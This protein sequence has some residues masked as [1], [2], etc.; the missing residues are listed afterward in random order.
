MTPTEWD[1]LF[2]ASLPIEVTALPLPLTE[3]LSR[4][5]ERGLVTGDPVKG[6]QITEKGCSLLE[7]RNIRD[8]LEQYFRGVRR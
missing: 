5:R 6:W 4:L 1:A 2:V 3:A 7:Y 8:D